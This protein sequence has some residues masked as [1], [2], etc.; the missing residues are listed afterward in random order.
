MMVDESASFALQVSS[1]E[2]KGALNPHDM[3]QRSIMADS[4]MI[5]EGSSLEYEQVYK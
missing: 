5:D 2:E 3:A 4:E 1:G